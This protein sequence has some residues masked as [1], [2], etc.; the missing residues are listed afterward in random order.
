MFYLTL[1]IATNNGD[2]FSFVAHD[3]TPGGWDSNFGCK[4]ELG[5]FRKKKIGRGNTKPMTSF[6][7]TVP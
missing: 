3:V 6:H 7:T 5:T 4:I 1:K 2:T